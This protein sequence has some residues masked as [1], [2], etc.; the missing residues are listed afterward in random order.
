M[1]HFT[2]HQFF[3]N[4]LGFHTLY[5]FHSSICP[6]HHFSQTLY[7]YMTG[8]VAL[9][10]TL[11]ASISHI[12]MYVYH[13]HHPFISHIQYLNTPE[14]DLKLVK[15][16]LTHEPQASPTWNFSTCSWLSLTSN[17]NTRSPRLQNQGNQVKL[18]IIPHSS[19]RPT[20]TINTVAM[21][22]VQLM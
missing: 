4:I 3:P 1:C 7:M 2:T 11:C 5:A 10:H 15:I 9:Q 12:H 8:T 20:C 16:L 19:Y 17:K 22:L 6:V 18:L 21:G 14:K 13:V